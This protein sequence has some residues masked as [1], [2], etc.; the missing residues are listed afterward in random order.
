MEGV[1]PSRDDVL[2]RR[3]ESAAITRSDR[4]DGDRTRDMKNSLRMLIRESRGPEDLHGREKK[5][6]A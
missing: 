3:H 1:W 6:H 4:A 2:L 5:V